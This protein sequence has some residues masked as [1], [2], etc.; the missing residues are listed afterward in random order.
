M[1]TNNHH[2][3]GKK[4]L[5]AMSEAYADEVFEEYEFWRN[6]GVR[7]FHN[8]YYP[9]MVCSC[10]DRNETAFVANFSHTPSLKEYSMTK[11]LGEMG[12][13]FSPTGVI[14]KK[15]DLYRDSMHRFP[16][17][18]CAEQHAANDLLKLVGNSL[19]IK[20]ELFFGKPVRTATD[21]DNIA[22]CDN[23]SNLF[24]L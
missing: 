19:N 10:T 13:E 16:I 23:C 12:Q 14:K 6:L 21:E 11:M 4:V 17:G 3:K 5:D 9:T 15:D 8:R 7:M 2:F 18:Q 24:D 1:A 20:N 22:Y